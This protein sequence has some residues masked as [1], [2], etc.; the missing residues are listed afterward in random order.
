MFRKLFVP[1]FLLLAFSAHSALGV[2]TSMHG[3]GLNTVIYVGTTFTVT[4]RT[5]FPKD[6]Q[7][8]IAFGLHHGTNSPPGNDLGE[9]VLTSTESDLVA[10]GHENTGPGQFNVHIKLP[11]T[12][13]T[14]SSVNERYKLT[15]VITQ[16]VS[17]VAAVMN[18]LIWLGFAYS[19]VFCM[20]RP[21]RCTNQVLLSSMTLSPSGFQ[22]DSEMA[23]KSCT[24]VLSWD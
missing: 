6:D 12:F 14:G 2:I 5:N 9:V 18:P 11:Y 19:I 24:G 21:V 23:L 15:A 7:F 1:V 8:Y 4:F 16:A 22:V 17:L 13:S 3:P 20:C 10:S